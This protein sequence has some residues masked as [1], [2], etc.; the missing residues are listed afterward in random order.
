MIDEIDHALV[1]SIEKE[2]HLKLDEVTNYDAVRKEI[3]DSLQGLLENPNREECP[4][5]YHL[6]VGAMYPNIILTN[7]LQPDAI[8]DDTTCASCDYNQGPDSTCQRKMTWTWRGEHFMA[9]KGEYNMLRNQIE[10][11]TFPGKR[12]DLPPRHFHELPRAEQEVLLKKRMGDYSQKVYGKK[13]ATKVVEKESIVCQRE[14]PFYVNTVRD[15]RDRRY[16]YKA[17]LKKW[18]KDLEVAQSNSDAGA[19]DQGKPCFNL[20]VQNDCYLRFSSDCS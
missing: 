20:S 1:F 16:Q 3:V 13:F 8:V 10:Q 11:E 7:R 18:K 6:D 2:G 9:S 19:I 4:S 14:N 5:I 15:F 12:P 17:L